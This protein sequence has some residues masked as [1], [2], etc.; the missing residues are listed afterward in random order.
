MARSAFQRWTA[1]HRCGAVCP[2]AIAAAPERILWGTDWP[3]PNIAKHMPNDGD[4]VDL[5][6]LMMPDA[7]MQ[8]LILV[9]NPH[10]LYHF[11]G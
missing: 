2:G 9:D 3:H 4:L 1:V 7:A 5:I 11:S 6:P 8:R 10:R